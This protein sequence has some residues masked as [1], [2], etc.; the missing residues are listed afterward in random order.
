MSNDEQLLS[1]PEDEKPEPP[2]DFDEEAVKQK[3]LVSVQDGLN[4]I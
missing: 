2:P 3:V 1:N 4:K